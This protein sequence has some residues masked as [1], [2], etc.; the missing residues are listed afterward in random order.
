L[1][2]K[3]NQ[4]AAPLPFAKLKE[5]L[6]QNED[7][8]IILENEKINEMLEVKPDFQERLEFLLEIARTTRKIKMEEKEEMQ[9][10][11]AELDE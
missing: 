2:S 5:N 1:L 8:R 10:D 9:K 6:M 11:F 3:Q 4:Y 7:L